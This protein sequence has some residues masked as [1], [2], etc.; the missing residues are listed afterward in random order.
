MQRILPFLIVLAAAT[1]NVSA[2]T[3][4]SKAKKIEQAWQLLNDEGDKALA[5]QDFK[6]AASYYSQA[7]RQAFEHSVQNEMAAKSITGMGQAFLGDR[8]YLDAD[9]CFKTAYLVYG[10]L[11]SNPIAIGALQQQIM[12][13]QKSVVGNVFPIGTPG[14]R[15][16]LTDIQVATRSADKEF[17][18]WTKAETEADETMQKGDI[19]GALKSLQK[20]Q[21]LAAGFRPVLNAPAESTEIAIAEIEM[22][23]KDPGLGKH[24]GQI[25]EMVSSNQGNSSD[26]R[27]QLNL[28]HA[29]AYLRDGQLKDAMDSINLALANIKSARDN[30]GLF[31]SG[32]TTKAE[33]FE[34]QGDLKQARECAE[35]ATETFENTGLTTQKACEGLRSLG[36]IERAEKHFPAAE[37]LFKKAVDN[38]EKG[39]NKGNPMLAPFYYELALTYLQMSPPK[40]ALAAAAA[41]QALGAAKDLYAKNN[42]ELQ[43]YENLMRVVKGKGPVPT[44]GMDITP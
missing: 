31:A 18:P 35:K 28:L 30:A 44:T 4:L 3:S 39:L 40:E 10:I 17:E 43:K 20:A 33:I 38:G 19:Q 13:T 26:M 42:P 22:M 23:R 34:A 15:K 2:D 11:E 6:R 37:K 27:R 16:V 36:R 12:L 24:L 14:I 32:Y 21:A 8:D 7:T 1:A 5:K 29:R 9:E 41:K 25:Q